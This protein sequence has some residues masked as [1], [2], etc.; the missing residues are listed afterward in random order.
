MSEPRLQDA[1]V[2]QRRDPQPPAR[3]GSSERLELRVDDVPEV[4]R[5]NTPAIVLG[6]LLFAVAGALGYCGWLL[7]NQQQQLAATHRASTAA[8]QRFETERARTR[9]QIEQLEQNKLEQAQQLQQGGVEALELKAA[10]AAAQARLEG[11]EAERAELGVQMAEYRKVTQQFRSM[12]DSGKLTVTFRR[13]RMI[14][15]LPAAVLFASGSA[16]LSAQG[17]TALKEVAAILGHVPGKRF[18]VAGHTDD[19][20][21]TKALTGYSSNWALSAAR[22]VIVTEA[23]L[24]AGLPP[25]HL[26][27]AGF[28]QYD[29][30][31]SNRA[32]AG[33]Q[34]NRRIEIV[35][36]PELKAFPSALDEKVKSDAGKK[37]ATTAE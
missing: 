32:P 9:Q 23:L 25:G 13:G 3:G 28:G 7:Q 31:A 20:P 14:V 4:S 11:L 22:A 18:I 8:V 36:E 6:V 37:T 29:P 26:S 12:I 35:L 1:P 10:L 34:K 30:I 16:E 2:Q 27:A 21:I 19:V 17:A 15:E 33:R 5:T 24:G